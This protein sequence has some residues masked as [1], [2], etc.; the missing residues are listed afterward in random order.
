[1]TYTKEWKKWK[2]NVFN[3]HLTS[4]F[5]H[6]LRASMCTV[7][8]TKH[9]FWTKQSLSSHRKTRLR[10]M[11]HRE[12]KQWWDRKW[13]GDYVRLGCHKKSLWRGEI[14]AEIQITKSQPQI[15]VKSIHCCRTSWLAQK[16]SECVSYS[17][18]MWLVWMSPLNNKNYM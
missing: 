17:Q 2:K 12:L 13:W 10:Q 1:M 8:S 16:K 5:G 3:I 15:G 9:W 14:E 4:I 11:L 18:Q 6:L 7:L